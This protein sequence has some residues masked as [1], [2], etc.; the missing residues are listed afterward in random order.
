MKIYSFEKLDA[1]VQAKTLATWIYK[2]TL[3][4]PDN[5]RFGIVSQMRRSA[6]SIGSNLAEGTARQ[7]GKDKA[8]FGNLAYSSTLELLNH[9]IISKELEFIDEASLLIGRA[10]IEKQ[11]LLITQRRKAQLQQ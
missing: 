5:E 9:L 8:H 2:L 4:F 10:Y 11:T 3:P 7:T 6:L 1:W